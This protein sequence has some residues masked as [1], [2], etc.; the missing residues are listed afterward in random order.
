[1]FL[2]FREIRFFQQ[3]ERA[4]ARFSEDTRKYTDMNIKSLLRF[5]WVYLGMD[6]LSETVRLLPFIIG[7]LLLCRG[8]EGITVGLLMALATPLFGS[9]TTSSALPARTFVQ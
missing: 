3:N 8:T 4:A 2:R 5:N 9:S 6:F 7:A 1:M